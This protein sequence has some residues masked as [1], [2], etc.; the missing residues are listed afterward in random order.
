M[1]RLVCLQQLYSYQN[2]TQV[3]VQFSIDILFINYFIII[4]FN[5]QYN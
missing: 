4:Y 1:V 3:I 5:L 2:K